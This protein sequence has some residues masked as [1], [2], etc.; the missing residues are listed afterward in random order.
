MPLGP[1]R[2]DVA[3]DGGEKALAATVAP[4]GDGKVERNQGAVLAPPLDLASN[5]DGIPFPGPA[6]AGQK[7]VL[8]CV[9]LRGHQHRHVSADG[10]IRRV[11]EDRLSRAVEGLDRPLVVEH[12]DSIHGGVQDGAQPRL[13]RGDRR[14]PGTERQMS[15]QDS[16]AQADELLHA[17]RPGS[18][19]ISAAPR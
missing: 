19:M 6:V 17:H 9:V 1:A 8:R 10:L 3:H 14:R 18:G 16:L 7:G 2:R 5:I 13:S 11:A 4:F 15:P 12:D